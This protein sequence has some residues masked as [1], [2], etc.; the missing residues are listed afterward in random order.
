MGLGALAADS[1][2]G[3]SRN[4]EEPADREGKQAPAAS[5]AEG[6]AGDKPTGK[7]QPSDTLTDRVS[8]VNRQS[9]GVGPVANADM[10]AASLE[11][12]KQEQFE[13]AISPVPE[14]PS[15]AGVSKRDR[16]YESA[17]NSLARE[18]VDT[19][20]LDAQLAE[21]RRAYREEKDINR[22]SEVAQMLTNSI[23]NY[24]AATW[25]AKHGTGGAAL[26]DF[27]ATDRD[28]RAR[29][30]EA[31]EEY[32]MESDLLGK[33]RKERF[34]RAD[35]NYEV[36]KD[37]LRGKGDLLDSA[38]SV[39]GQDMQGYE[40]AMRTRRD[41][42]RDAN[43]RA[44]DASKKT[45]TEKKQERA[46]ANQIWDNMQQEEKLLQPELREIDTLLKKAQTAKSGKEQ[47]A[48]LGALAAKAGL[49]DEELEA[50]KED[51]ANQAEGTL[52]GTNESTPKAASAV[53]NKLYAPIK[54]RLDAIR[55]EKA[56]A[57]AVLGVGQAAPAAT[58]PATPAS[59][60]AAQA[61]AAPRA[62]T[63]KAVEEY[64][65]KH[66]N[67]DIEKARTALKSQGFAPE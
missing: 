7:S 59:A 11:P 26:P 41:E 28:Y 22:W 45:E 56:R 15:K 43:Q 32:Q 38:R 65:K 46:L 48:A 57:G 33:S 54:Q 29:N 9:T 42:V 27:S 36:K 3:A 49:S 17:I 52:W 63:K 14:K 5:S 60:S 64:A 67:G 25:A 39:Y 58:Q 31:R 47:E 40:S 50:I 61:P 19:S 13:S 34:D 12:K 4:A 10:Y 55:A 62:V 51:P 37:Q 66:Y 18:N 35:K 8:D 23:A 6:G 20:D 44:D 53:A 21:A 24:A 2:S 16:D 30:K 1:K